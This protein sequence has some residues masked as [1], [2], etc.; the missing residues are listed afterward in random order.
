MSEKEEIKNI[1]F[2]MNYDRSKTLLEQGSADFRV[3]RKSMSMAGVDYEDYR[4]KL[5]QDMNDVVDFFSDPHVL[6]P[7]GALVLTIASG[8]AASP[9]LAAALAGTSLALEAADVALYWK[10]GDHT[11]AGI[12]AIFALIPGAQ[13]AKQLGLRFV[14]EMTEQEIKLFLRKI[15]EGLDLTNKEKQ[16]LQSINNN[17]TALRLLTSRQANKAATAQFL[18]RY[19]RRKLLS[20]IAKLKILGIKIHR[21]GWKITAGGV[22]FLT[23]L[24]MGKILGLKAAEFTNAELPESYTQ[25]SEEKKEEV[26]KEINNKLETNSDELREQAYNITVA[27][28]ETSDEEK[29]KQYADALA[30][31]QKLLDEIDF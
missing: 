31:Q 21:V 23:V 4:N 30:E 18:Y 25:L 5:T 22:G 2:L 28:I 13:L 29:N 17:K 11:S 14:S 9:L 10:E 6:L 26:K 12:G 7:L 20:A 15:K 1:V 27:A 24:Q 8:G 19:S 3:D 16:L